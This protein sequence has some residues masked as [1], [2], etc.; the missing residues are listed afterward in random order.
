MSLF[1]WIGGPL[2]ADT[3][4]SG[5]VGTDWFIA[6]NWSSGIPNQGDDVTIPSGLTNYPSLN[7]N[8]A[9]CKSLTINSGGTLDLTTFDLKIYRHF[10][11]QAS[12]VLLSTASGSI[13]FA[14]GGFDEIS[15]DISFAGDI[16]LNENGSGNTVIFNGNVSC[17][18]LVISRGAAELTTTGG[19]FTTTLSGNLT[20]QAGSTLERVNATLD[21]AGDVQINGTW[22]D[23]DPD[24]GTFIAGNW[25]DSGTFLSGTQRVTFDGGGTSLVTTPGVSDFYDL[26]I[27]SSTTVT[28]SSDIDIDNSATI[29]GG[30]TLDVDGDLDVTGGSVICSGSG[31]LRIGATVT[32]LGTFTAGGGTVE[33][34]SQT[35]NQALEIVTY[36]NLEI[37]TGSFSA[38]ASGTYT[39]GGTTNVVSGTLAIGTGGD[40]TATGAVSVDGTL[41]L[42]DGGDLRLGTSVTINSGGTFAAS[43]TTIPTV[44]ND[45]SGDYTFTVS[46]GGTI[47]VLSL[48]FFNPEST[49]LTISDGATIAN[50]RRVNFQNVDPDAD[51]SNDTFL[52]I[53]DSGSSQYSL[54]GLS[55]DAT[56]TYNVETAAGTSININMVIPTGLGGLEVYENEGTVGSIDWPLF[57]RT[58]LGGTSGVETDW[59]V[60]LNWSPASVPSATDDCLVGSVTWDPILNTTGNARSIYIDTGGSLTIDTSNTMNFDR[61]LIVSSSGT[62]SMTAG[63][64]NFNGTESQNLDHEGGATLTVYDLVINKSSGVMGSTVDA[65]ITNDFTVTA[66]T[67]ALGTRTFT[68]GGTTDINGTLTIST[69]A[70]DANGP[71]D[72]T[73]GAVTFTGAGRLE[74]GNTVT[75]LGTFTAIA[76]TVEYDDS[77]ANRSVANV[78]YDHLE[79]DCGTRT[80]STSGSLTIAGDLTV[81]SGTFAAGSNTVTVTGAT[82][83]NGTLTISTGTVDANGPF[84]ATG[85][86]VTFS[87]AG[88]LQLGDAVTSLGTFT[89]STGTVEFDDQISDQT[90]P[91]LSYQNLEIDKGTRTATNAGAL[92]V[93]GTLTMTSGTLDVSGTINM[94]GGATTFG[95]GRLELGG[96]VTSFGTFTAGTGTVVYDDTTAGRTI[97]VATYFNLEIDTGAQVALTGGNVTVTN[98]LAILSGELEVDDADTL[99][100]DNNVGVTGTLDLEPGSALLLGASTVL[101]VDGMFEA[102]GTANDLAQ[103]TASDTATPGRYS[104][105]VDAEGILNAS[106]AYFAYMDAFGLQIT[107]SASVTALTQFDDVYLAYGAPGGTLLTIM[108]N[109][110]AVTLASVYFE[111]PNSNLANNVV[112]QAATAAI[113]FDPYG[114]DFGG[115]ANEDD[116]GGGTV[117]PGFII[118]GASTPARLNTFA[119]TAG[120]LDVVLGW[121]TSAEWCCLGFQL[122]RAASGGSF[123]P[124]GPELI[125]ARGVAP[126]GASYR[127][128]DDL[129]GAHPGAQY[130]LIEIDQAGRQSQLGNTVAKHARGRAAGPNQMDGAAQKLSEMGFPRTSRRRVGTQLPVP[131]PTPTASSSSALTQAS[132]PGSSAALRIR[133]E[134]DGMLRLRHSDLAAAGFPVG[135]DPTRFRLRRD[136][137]ACPIFIVGGADGSFDPGDAIDFLAVPFT[138]PETKLDVYVLDLV[139]PGLTPPRIPEIA[140]APAFSTAVVGASPHRIEFSAEDIYVLSL[141]DGAG[142]DHWFDE[143]LASPGS[144]EL[145][146]ELAA[147]APAATPTLVEL[148]LE[149]WSEDRLAPLDHLTRVLWDGVEIGV[150]TANGSGPYCGTFSVPAGLV[151]NGSHL[152]TLEQ[153]L[154]DTPD[155]VFLDTLRVTYPRLYSAAADRL[156][157]RIAGG[158][159]VRFEGFTSDAISVYQRSGTDEPRRIV[160]AAVSSISP[161]EWAVECTLPHGGVVEAFTDAAARGAVSLE[162]R[163]TETTLRAALDA[164]WIAICPDAFRSE[165]LPLE[166]LRRATGLR[167]AVVSLEEI[168][169]RFD[170]GRPTSDAIERFIENALEWARPPGPAFLL[171][172]GDA[173]YDPAGHLGNS[174]RQILPTPLIEVGSIQTASDAH[175]GDLDGDGVPELAVG[176]F[177]VATVLECQTMV[178]KTIAHDSPG[179]VL[180]QPRVLLIGDDGDDFDGMSAV[181]PPLLPIGVNVHSLELDTMPI[182]ALRTELITIE[183]PSATVVHY[184]GHG[185]RQQWADEGILLL[186][187]MPA[188]SPD[189]TPPLVI[190]MNCLNG[191]FQHPGT[192]SLGEAL[193][194]EPAG[195]AVAFFGPTAVTTTLRQQVFAEALYSSLFLGSG[196]RIGDVICNA[197]EQ[198]ADD[199][200][201]ADVIR[202]WVLLGDPALL[203]Q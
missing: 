58:W 157:A 117:T 120:A 183:W 194:V 60:A 1:L 132:A 125:P 97:L 14:G 45:G 198:L 122:E 7:A 155:V 202:S 53:L 101:T 70:L 63:T 173:T 106:S 19:S 186:S 74:L 115:A 163:G 71:F 135:V 138:H 121:E 197:Q 20:I 31:R 43:G 188:L 174:P 153:E 9:R 149:G 126:G 15:G 127:L 18:D 182:S 110:N 87:G 44:T 131:T 59:D 51:G 50:L 128:V 41:L 136:D 8:G 75:S 28:V 79:I 185:S 175:Y 119:A 118:W 193:V 109:D 5:A 22:D 154:L 38:T 24:G 61:D 91:I 36:N 203:V 86:S 114:G 81:T 46:S 199:P 65:T 178:Q 160:G 39:V 98:D 133:V 17:N 116:N 85:G 16:V 12:N 112:T 140:G 166:A 2:R 134:P 150:A 88:R 192:P 167:T 152:I 144:L 130:R 21:I 196:I 177:P 190:A 92:V 111:D 180:P 165:I 195:G 67:A 48:E 161:A 95:S 6:S 113:T 169:D 49:G 147:V 123:T 143:F 191:F 78:S 171:L 105:A 37:D 40:V 84:D 124:I 94:T 200:E 129:P 159:T 57:T 23:T 54:V 52:R 72:A 35:T 139:A 176:R 146:V 64:L 69:G 100:V 25:I 33:Y 170:G 11:P 47:N 104:F 77:T 4:W 108:D 168:Y 137:E 164:D 73:G 181:I 103:V 151:S 142:R 42:A 82:D 201:N 76:S 179:R 189:P 66:G 27:T 187:D 29:N 89:P 83:V 99:Q 62:F 34:D 10:T 80:V 184:T 26:Q 55:F 32:S 30:C 102:I 56:C 93:P 3:T 158:S 141:A 145:L 162:S 156:R 13:T 96:A 107:D 172:V 148:W 90:V 68:V